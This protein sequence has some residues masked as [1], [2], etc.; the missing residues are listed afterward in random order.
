MAT[1]GT[2]V[3]ELQANTA[4]FH[5]ELGRASQR[6]NE[7]G[8][9]FSS[10]EHTAAS[11]AAKGIGAVVPA[12][13]GFENAIGRVISSALRAGSAL[14]FGGLAAV[15]FGTGLALVALTRKAAEFA[16]L[17]ESVSAFEERMK[18]AAEEQQKFFDK[19][20]L[21]ISRNIALAREAAGFR[22][23]AAGLGLESVGDT[24]GA[25]RTRRQAALDELEL[26]V[27]DRQVVERQKAID[28][29]I[30][31]EQ[32]AAT[33]IEIERTATAARVKINAEA[34]KAYADLDKQRL[35]SEKTSY[36]ASTTA[37]VDQ[38]TKRIDL[39]KQLEAKTQ[40]LVDTGAIADPFGNAE[41]IRKQAQTE[42]EGF[43]L[44]LDKGR[45][46]TDLEEQIF[47]KD[48][49]FQDK[50]FVGFALAVENAQGKFRALGISATSLEAEWS[51]I[52]KRLGDDLPAAINRA[53]PALAQLTSR[54]RA[55]REEMNATIQ[56]TATL[57]NVIAGG[58]A[59]EPIVTAPVDLGVNP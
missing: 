44:L 20:S 25:I 33:L 48:R 37:L 36:L 29:K 1:V 23:Q 14:R 47:A 46:W 7:T 53:D 32:L 15:G 58:N 6:L 42:A 22:G 24:E 40:G 2:I 30:N 39:R 11:F 38:I 13:D 28:G 26:E 45:R 56:T 21:G 54:I 3:V 43:A 35:E 19:L 16:A 5:Q 59:P 8:R 52:S 4:Q 27:Q 18:K 31:A 51:G 50:G 10:A 34:G 55:M 49:E 9:G 17:G 12:A 41:Q 57:A